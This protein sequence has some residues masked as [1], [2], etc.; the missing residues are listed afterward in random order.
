MWA[1]MAVLTVWSGRVPPFQLAAMAFT[2]AFAL[3]A[4]SWLLRG[5]ALIAGQELL[6]RSPS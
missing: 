3:A 6:R 2:L 1:T 4:A 5:G